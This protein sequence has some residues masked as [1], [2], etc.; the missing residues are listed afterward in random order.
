M[1]YVEFHW[2]NGNE[3]RL[4]SSGRWQWR[5]YHDRAWYWANEDWTRVS[6]QRLQRRVFLSKLTPEDEKPMFANLC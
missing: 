4:M 2:S 1:I 5:Q 3:T 6:E